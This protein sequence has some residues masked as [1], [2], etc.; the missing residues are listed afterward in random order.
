VVALVVEDTAEHWIGLAARDV[1]ET[2]ERW[3]V[4][5]GAAA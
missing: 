3:L 2:A 5:P 4:G 1:L